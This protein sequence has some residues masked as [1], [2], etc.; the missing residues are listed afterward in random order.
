MVA[1]QLELMMVETCRQ[2]RWFSMVSFAI[3]VVST[4]MTR[5]AAAQPEECRATV[6]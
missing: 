4:S 3:G 6:A 5:V 1:V 2:D